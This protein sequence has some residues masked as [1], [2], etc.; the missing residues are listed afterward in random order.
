MKHNIYPDDYVASTYDIDFAALAKQGYEGVIFDVDNTLV[1]HDI[2]RCLGRKSS[3]HSFGH[4][5]TGVEMEGRDSD[6]SEE[7]HRS[8]GNDSVS[9]L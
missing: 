4:G 5:K 7:I 9:S 1:P 6:Y 8:I 2:Y 3:W